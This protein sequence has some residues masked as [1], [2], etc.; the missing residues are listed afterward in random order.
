MSCS[1]A[2]LR[3]AK[4]GKACEDIDECAE[5]TDEC[6]HQCINKDPRKSG[7][8]YACS[9][10]LGYSLD[11]QDRHNCVKTVRYLLQCL[12]RNAVLLQSV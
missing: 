8:P 7:I 10:K 1:R 3:L 5:H 2:G 9:C 4:D 12:K 6:D 11:L